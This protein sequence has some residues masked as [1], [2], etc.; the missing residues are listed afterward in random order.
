M[1]TAVS[2]PDDIFRDSDRLARRLGTSRSR[3]YARALTDFLARHGEEEMTQG[4]NQVVDQAG[5]GVD[6]FVREASRQALRNVEW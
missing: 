4:M 2:I 5:P 1:K 3:L 6:G